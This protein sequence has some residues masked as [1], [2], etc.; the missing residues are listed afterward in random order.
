MKLI[1]IDKNPSLKDLR[2]FCALVI[3][4]FFGILGGVI[5]YKFGYWE[6][7]RVVWMVAGAIA[8]VGLIFP[9]FARVVYVGW[10]TAFAPVGFVISHVVL[11]LTFY[12][13][14][15]PVGLIMRLVGYDPMERKIDKEAGS[16]WTERE[17]RRSKKSYFRQY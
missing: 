14:M 16:Y 15:T 17:Q 8:V 9:P 13:L 4:L 7:I 3:P 11:G 1:E 10:M 12:G 5:G 2:I 6:I